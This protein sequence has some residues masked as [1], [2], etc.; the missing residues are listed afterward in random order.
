MAEDRCPNCG[1]EV[2][3]A[4]GQ[5]ASTPSAGVVQ[6]PQCGAKVTLD[7]PGAEPEQQSSPPSGEVPGAREAPAGE[8]TGEDYF[9]GEETV[10]GVMEEVRE[11][12]DG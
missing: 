4:T 9:S 12:E 3:R 7:K 5:H 6:C 11:K 10:E 8:P 2:P 1:A